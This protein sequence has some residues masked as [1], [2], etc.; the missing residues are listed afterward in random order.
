MG[1]FVVEEFVCAFPLIKLAKKLKAFTS[2]QI[3]NLPLIVFPLIKLAKKLKESRLENYSP[4]L[5]KKGGF[6]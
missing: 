5:K 2:N 1:K 6:H 3:Q 4:S